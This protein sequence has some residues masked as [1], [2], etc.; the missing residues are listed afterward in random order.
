[1]A[2]PLTKEACNPTTPLSGSSPPQGENN[3]NLTA[4]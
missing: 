3:I 4:R 1:V 2:N